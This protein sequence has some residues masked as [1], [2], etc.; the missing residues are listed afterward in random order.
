MK[1]FLFMKR[2]LLPILFTLLSHAIP[3]GHRLISRH[4]LFL[5][6]ENYR[7]GWF[8]SLEKRPVRFIAQDGNTV[9]FF[10]Y[11]SEREEFSGLSSLSLFGDKPI[12]GR[13]VFKHPNLYFH[14]TQFKQLIWI[15]KIDTLPYAQTESL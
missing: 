2:L 15:G 11:D 1:P 13:W 14:P 7:A 8:S 4:Q 10:N 6:W 12:P 5:E 9:A 3:H